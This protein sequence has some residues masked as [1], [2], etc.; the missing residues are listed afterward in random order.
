M[1]IYHWPHLL[2]L[3][4]YYL[5]VVGCTVSI[6]IVFVRDYLDN[7]THSIQSSFL[8]FLWQFPA[9]L[10]REFSQSAIPPLGRNHCKIESGEFPSNLLMSWRRYRQLTIE[11]VR[12]MSDDTTEVVAA[13]SALVMD[14]VGDACT[15]TSLRKVWDD[16]IHLKTMEIEGKKGW[17]C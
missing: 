10:W 12:Q 5:T 8:H 13:S 14:V 7:Y 4:S 15:R 2:P 3:I 17:R 6:G 9:L 11:A 1:C 16:A